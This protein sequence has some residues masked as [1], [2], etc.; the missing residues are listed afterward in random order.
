MVKNTREYMKYHI[1]ELWRK[2][3]RHDWSSQLCSQLSEIKVKYTPMSCSPENRLCNE[4]IIFFVVGCTSRNEQWEHSD[5]PTPS[6]LLP[7]S[8]RVFVRNHTCVCEMCSTNM[9]MFMQIRFIFIWKLLHQD[10][11]RKRVTRY[12]GNGVLNSLMNN[13]YKNTEK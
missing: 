1:F 12:F 2:I 10:V 7:V 5:R 4:I 13:L 11:F 3:W 8:K 9:F 6:C